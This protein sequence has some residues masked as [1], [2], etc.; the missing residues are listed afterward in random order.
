MDPK[1]YSKP[2]QSALPLAPLAEERPIYT[3]WWF[4]TACGVA[5][6]LAGVIIATSVPASVRRPASS[7]G[8]LGLGF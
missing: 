5:L 1:H 6:T 8:A 4:W 3:Q 2:R 7:N